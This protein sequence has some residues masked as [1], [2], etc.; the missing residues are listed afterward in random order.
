MNFL[1]SVWRIMNLLSID[2][3]LGAMAGMLFFADL[4][5]VSLPFALYMVLGMAV[6]SVYTL[7]HLLDARKT[8]Q[9]ASS[10]RH[11]FHQKHFI[12]LGVA[13]AIIVVSGFGMVL[14]IEN[15]QY[16]LYPGLVF[17]IVM[18]L[19]MGFLYLIGKKVSWLK[20]LSTAVFYVSGIAFGPFM[21]VYPGEIPFPFYYY[22]LGYLL[23]ASVNLYMLSFM[24]EK[25]DRRDGFASVLQVLSKSGLKNLIWSLVLIGVLAMLIGLLFLPSYYRIH[26]GI[27]LL[28]FLFHIKEFY[29]ADGVSTRKKLEA[30]FLLP[31]ILLL[32]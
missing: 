19:W 20:E 9:P 18:L 31:L 17:G 15:L 7:D 2:V 14:F 24:D 4:L 10:E 3:A 30:S 32:F 11:R 6:W 27:L 21:L 5:D 23:L 25:T 12:S 26:A 1:R 13:F 28:L 8:I 22:W 16:I 29:A